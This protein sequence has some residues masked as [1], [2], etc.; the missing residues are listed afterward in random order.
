MHSVPQPPAN[1]AAKTADASLAEA[2]RSCCRSAWEA[3]YLRFETPEQEIRKFARRL[4]ALGA[5]SWSRTAQVVELFCGRGNGLHALARFGF[6]N[7]EGIDLSAN[8]LARYTGPARVQ[9]ADCRSLPFPD[10][11]R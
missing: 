1:P 8:L 10:E 9:V 6:T 7:L 4:H 2:S 3:A 11:S 5:D